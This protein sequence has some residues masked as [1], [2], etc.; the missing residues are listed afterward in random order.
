[1]TARSEPTERNTPNP[2]LAGAVGPDRRPNPVPPERCG[3]LLWAGSP[4]E[5]ARNTPTPHAASRMLLA[6]RSENGAMLAARKGRRCG[7]APRFIPSSRSGDR[8]R[9]P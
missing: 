8:S 5:K 4:W 7:Q 3:T 6:E 2:I 1:M 9:N